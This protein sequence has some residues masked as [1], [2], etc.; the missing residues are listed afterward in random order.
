MPCGKLGDRVRAGRGV[1]HHLV[2]GE[3][4]L[5][6]QDRA[7]R[8]EDKSRRARSCDR[9]R[10]RAPAMILTTRR[11]TTSTAAA[12]P[13]PAT[14]TQPGGGPPAQPRRRGERAGQPGPDPATS[15]RCR[16]GPSSGN[17]RTAASSSG[18]TRPGVQ[19][20]PAVPGSG[21]RQAPDRLHQLGDGP[22]GQR[23]QRDHRALDDGAGQHQP[24]HEP[25]GQPGRRATRG[26][27]RPALSDSPASSSRTTTAST[28]FSAPVLDRSAVP[29]SRVGEVPL[30]FV[31][32]TQ[33][34][35]GL[36]LGGTLCGRRLAEAR[37]VQQAPGE[38][39]HRLRSGVLGAERQAGAELDDPPGHQR[40]V[41]ALRHDQ[42]R[43]PGVHRLVDAVHPTVRDEQRRPGQHLELRHGAAGQHVGRQ[44]TQV[45]GSVCPVETTT[46]P[47]SGASAVAKVRSSAGPHRTPCPA[48]RT[49]PGPRAGRRRNPDRPGGSRRSP[50]RTGTTGRTRRL[51]AGT[52]GR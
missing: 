18:A 43:H 10:F 51:R 7:E 35:A 46:V 50:R 42:R 36:L 19:A 20:S 49:A 41:R 30:E 13:T 21:A 14:A 5:G 37:L 3:Q 33:I 40:L 32:G 47:P 11:R 15:S 28:S 48:R 6:E 34:A 25:R 31:G 8:Q 26:R 4:A 9:L 45:A 24:G 22:R 12:S 44:R 39:M 38:G 52:R 23:P 27:T 2:A 29:P 17:A 1:G 16:R